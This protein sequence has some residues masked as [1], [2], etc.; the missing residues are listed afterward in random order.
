MEHLYI[1]YIKME[2]MY[3]LYI[4]M[5]LT[6]VYLLYIHYTQNTLNKRIILNQKI[7]IGS[8]ESDFSSLGDLLNSHKENGKLKDR[9][10]KTCKTSLQTYE[11][12]LQ[13]QK[14]YADQKNVLIQSLIA[15][16]KV[17]DNKLLKMKSLRN[18]ETILD[19]KVM[20]PCCPD[21]QDCGKKISLSDMS[22]HFEDC[23]Y[24]GY[25]ECQRHLSLNTD[26][27]FGWT[28]SDLDPW[29]NKSVVYKLEDSSNWFVLMACSVRD[30]FSIFV[31]HHCEHELK[32]LFYFKLRLYGETDVTGRSTICR[33]APAGIEVEDAVDNG[34]T[35]DVSTDEMENICLTLNPTAAMEKYRIVIEFSVIKV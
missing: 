22:Q 35:M 13:E 19:F 6:S 1:I 9:I 29:S 30:S 7:V 27:Q 32:D 14:R 24:L 28:L 10:L 34:Y 5:L 18:L 8:L 23:G 17:K 15:E 26:V 20:S 12:N 3:A 25:V 16:G 31:M 21:Y 2:Y 33:C 11:V 4:T